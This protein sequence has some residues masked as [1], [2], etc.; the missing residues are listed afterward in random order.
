MT[1][2]EHVFQ[3]EAETVHSCNWGFHASARRVVNDYDSLI[4]IDS[5]TNDTIYKYK[6]DKIKAQSTSQE[7]IGM[8]LVP[9]N[10]KN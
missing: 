7:Q 4:M 9:S 2:R 10:D 6:S 5:N 8:P 1:F 3:F